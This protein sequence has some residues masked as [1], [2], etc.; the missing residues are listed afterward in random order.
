MA[1][2]V[3][4]RL[5]IHYCYRSESFASIKIFDSKGAIGKINK[6][7]LCLQEVNQLNADMRSLPCGSVPVSCS[8]E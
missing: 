4:D 8:M 7:Q 6:R 1:N 5:F 3:H 2:P